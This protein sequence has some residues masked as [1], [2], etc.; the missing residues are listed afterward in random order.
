MH[1]SNP[2]AP[3]WQNMLATGEGREKGAKHSSRRPSAIP[4]GS[5]GGDRLPFAL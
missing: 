5:T 3:A 1:L 4:G 2:G